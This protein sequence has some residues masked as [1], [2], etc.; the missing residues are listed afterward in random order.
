M[1][2]QTVLLCT[3]GGSHQPVVT[4]I[5][6]L[7]PARVV[8]LCSEP[9][10]GQTGSCVQVRGK[11]MCIKA[12]PADE[13]PTLPNIPT[14]CNLGADTWEIVAVPPDD[15][16]GA[17]LVM[18]GAIER[19]RGLCPDARLIADITGGTKTMTA[20]LMLVALDQDGVALQFVTGARAD[21]VKV[22]D[23]TQMIAPVNASALRLRRDMAPLLGA[24]Q[25]YAYDE[26][27]QG[28]AR[29]P[30]PSD[31]ALLRTLMSARH[32]SQ[33]LSAWDRFDH[34]AAL[35]LLEPYKPL[36]ASILQQGWPDLK[37]LA[38]GASDDPRAEGLRIW[39]LWLN[40]Q[41]RAAA[42]RYDDAVARAYR[43]LEWVAQ[44]ILKSRHGWSTADLPG[45]V[46]NAAGISAN[47]EG[48]YQ[49]GLYAAWRLAAE[50][51]GEDIR[52]FYAE[53]GAAMLNHVR[54]RN[55]SILA[56]GFTPVSASDWDSFNA[57]LG[58]A[59]VPLLKS[60]LAQ[61]RIREPFPQLPDRYPTELLQS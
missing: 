40:A 44:W 50:H 33:A 32:F 51:A 42:G 45:D 38:G 29:L 16:D 53:H 26:A 54:Q 6:E 19:A 20:A 8:F 30:S 43:T 57:W 1:D 5:R 31:P 34:A 60:L 21:L 13:K 46:A 10:P 48:K 58:N 3:V 2:R 61:H 59:L 17:C 4:A 35:L 47:G 28:L 56:H 12:R 15:L 22:Q 23:G 11:G 49:A 18:R 25:R 41:R 39:D 24:W 36:A 27:A 9:E 37:M 55:G 7:A 52:G 14:Q